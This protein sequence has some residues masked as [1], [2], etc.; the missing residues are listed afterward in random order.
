MNFSSIFAAAA[1]LLALLAMWSQG[2][3]S[4]VQENASADVKE[5]V[6]RS[7]TLGTLWVYLAVIIAF[8]SL[9][10]FL[11]KEHWEGGIKLIEAF[12]FGFFIT[13]FI[14]ASANMLESIITLSRRII[15]GGTLFDSPRGISSNYYGRPLFCKIM[16]IVC[17]SLLF[18][19]LGVVLPHWWLL[20]LI[21]VWG[22]GLILY[23]KI[24]RN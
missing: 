7:A 16:G 9:A 10:L 12:G 15:R 5:R 13:A 19:T 14:M 11:M 23:I 21:P 18:S 6:Q 17:S 2:W 3:R 20:G 4:H 24:T 22:Y 1:I 8:I